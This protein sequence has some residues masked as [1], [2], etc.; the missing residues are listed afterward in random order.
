MNPRLIS[1]IAA[2]FLIGCGKPITSPTAAPTSTLTPTP[3]ATATPSITP[4][5]VGYVRHYRVDILKRYPHDPTAFTQGLL[6]AD[7]LLYEGTGYYQT[8]LREIELETGE[9]LRSTQSST[10]HFGE[11]L[12]LI[13]DEFIQLTWQDQIAYRYDRVTLAVLDT[14]T[15]TGEGWGL[16]F[17]GTHLYQSDGTATLTVRDPATF[18]PL[19]TLTVTHLNEPVTQLNELECVG[20]FI[21]ANVW[22][23]DQIMEINKHTGEVVGVVDASG[24]LPLDERPTDGNA[25]LN[26]IAYIPE[27]ETFLLTGKLWP[28]L[29]EVNFTPLD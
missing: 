27:R 18:D 15:Y 17:D 1:V 8:M 12:A 13:G 6:W 19:T 14:Y 9:I 21:Y 25:V 11:G 20:E 5:P 23:T 10:T 3:T 7:G 4:T 2:F 29:F 26:G 24:L 16:C 22:F 28:A